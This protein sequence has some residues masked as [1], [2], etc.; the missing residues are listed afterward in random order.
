MHDFCLE[1]TF[2]CHVTNAVAVANV[3]ACHPFPLEC[4]CAQL[5]CNILYVGPTSVMCEGHHCKCCLHCYR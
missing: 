2:L 5:S 3:H 4:V 1:D